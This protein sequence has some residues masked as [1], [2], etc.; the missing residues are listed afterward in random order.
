VK[1]AL[2]IKDESPKRAAIEYLFLNKNGDKSTIIDLFGTEL[3]EELRTLSYIS[4][5]LYLDKEGN[6]KESWS[7][8]EKANNY[9]NLCI[10]DLTDK[11]KERGRYLHGIGT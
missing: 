7:S 5:G 6:S 3:V 2:E 1:V 11:E 4:I 9:Y 8:T 10:K